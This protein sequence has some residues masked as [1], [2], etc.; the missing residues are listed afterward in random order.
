M[1]KLFVIMFVF[2]VSGSFV[3]ELNS[4]CLI[5]LPSNAMLPRP[6]SR[7]SQCSS[8]QGASSSSIEHS[9]C[10]IMGTCPRIFCVDHNPT[11]VDAS[12]RG[13]LCMSAPIESTSLC[14]DSIFDVYVIDD[15]A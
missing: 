1:S 4:R 3:D 8:T 15:T 9:I 2:G 7:K 5:A 10:P 13:T 12:R 11:F 14:K 6:P